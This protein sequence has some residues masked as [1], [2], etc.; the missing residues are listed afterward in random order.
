MMNCKLAPSLDSDNLCEPSTIAT[1]VSSILCLE[2]LTE[3]M[4]LSPKWANAI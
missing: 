4:R 3:E 1:Q 2:E